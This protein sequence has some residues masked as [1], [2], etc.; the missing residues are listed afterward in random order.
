LMLSTKRERMP[1]G[2]VGV[3]KAAIIITSRRLRR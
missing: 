3:L 1:R 2:S